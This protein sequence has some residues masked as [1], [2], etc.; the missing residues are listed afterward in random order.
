MRL[1]VV[2]LNI[3]SL[4]FIKIRFVDSCDFFVKMS[5]GEALIWRY[6]MKDINCLDSC[7]LINH[8]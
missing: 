4:G 2:G 3:R 6:K 5:I 8:V 1:F 7:L